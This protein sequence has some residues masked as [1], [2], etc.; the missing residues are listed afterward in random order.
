MAEIDLAC[1]S[2]RSRFGIPVRLADFKTSFDINAAP[3]QKIAEVIVG[4]VVEREYTVPCGTWVGTC[5]K[6]VGL[7]IAHD[8]LPTYCRQGL[9][10]EGGS[11]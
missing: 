3:A 10:Q 1:G 6:A 9:V 7:R 5:C 2:W 8:K 4:R 11:W